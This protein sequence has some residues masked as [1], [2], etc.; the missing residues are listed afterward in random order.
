MFNVYKFTNLTVTLF[1]W[2][3]VSLQLK[4]VLKNIYKD[5]CR[6]Y[7]NDKTLNSPRSFTKNASLQ[8]E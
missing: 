5:K 8:F 3:E 6:K 2:T 7:E 4:I 1:T